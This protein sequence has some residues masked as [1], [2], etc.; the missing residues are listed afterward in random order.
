MAI[1]RGITAEEEAASGLMWCLRELEYVGASYLMP[2]NHVH[3]H[4][5]I[6]FLRIIGLF[7]GQT[8][9]KTLKEYGLHIK[10]ED[11]QR[12]LMLA[13]PI[14]VAGEDTWAYPIPPLNFGVSV[15]GTGLPP[16]YATQISA[17]VTAKGANSIKSYLKK[18]ANLRN[19]IL[20]AGPDGYPQVPELKAE[21]IQEKTSH[22]LTLLQTYLLIQPYP[23]RQPYVQD[24]LTAFLSVVGAIG[25]QG[26]ASNEV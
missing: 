21:F 23:E 4:A 7:F 5:A 3:K 9:D 20:Y 6:P 13:F 2:R 24:A 26:G 14:K 25:S 18:E 22:V 19:E 11:G 12:R 8:F 10:D 16:S 15:A 1:F 17:Y